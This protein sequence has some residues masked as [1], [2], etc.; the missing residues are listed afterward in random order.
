[1]LLARP[2]PPMV[3]QH[4]RGAREGPTDLARVGAELL[5]DPGV[6]IP[7]LAHPSPPTWPRVNLR[8]GDMRESR[9]ETEGIPGR[10]YEPDGAR[11][12]L[13]LGH[14]G[15]GSKDEERFVGLARQYAEGTGL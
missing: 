2:G 13:L 8:S 9:I 11:G 12:L 15:G 5:D 7:G 4:H 14:G 6:E 1:A 10:L 3:Q